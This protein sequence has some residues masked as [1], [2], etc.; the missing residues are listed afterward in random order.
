MTGVSVVRL[1]AVPPGAPGTSLRL[2]P[3]P[4]PEIPGSVS[5]PNETP[6]KYH[7]WASSC[8][9]TRSR[10]DGDSVDNGLAGGGD[11]RRGIWIICCRCLGREGNGGVD[12]GPR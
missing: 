6:R 10:E 5:K 2:Q 8:T 11:Y 12:E 4:A 9:G 7:D 3:L 1:V